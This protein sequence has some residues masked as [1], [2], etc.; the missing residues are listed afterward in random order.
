MDE[1]KTTN[2]NT[3]ENANTVENN[4][5]V[6]G[7]SEDDFKKALESLQSSNLGQEKYAKRQYF[8]S[9][10]SAFC[11]IAALCIVIY[12]VSILI[13]RVDSLLTDVEGTMTNVQ[14]I[15]A[16]LATVDIAGIA[17][18]VDSLMATSETSITEAMD[19]LNGI[20]FENLN[21]A[22]A[23]LESVV[24]PLSSLFGGARRTPF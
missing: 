17:N 8:M 4:Q 6:I 7:I 5:T 3:A 9:M 14:K 22:I 15:T 24:R 20:D 1:N 13:P 12:A 21:K 10:L 11:S 23:E 2:E 19:K 16:D 18:N